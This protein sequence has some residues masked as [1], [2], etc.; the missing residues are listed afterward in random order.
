MNEF[1]IETRD[2]TRKFGKVIAVD[3]INIKVPK[4]S[5]YG[6]LGPNGAGKTTTIRMLLDLIRPDEGEVKLFDASLRDNRSEYLRRIGA[7]VETPSLYPHL[8]GGENMEITRL[9][10]SGTKEQVDKSL[11]FT[12][13][14]ESK[15]L[16]VKKYSHGM[17]QRL[18]LAL[19][20]IAD[21]ELLILDEPLSGL[22]PK[23]ILEFREMIN[24]LPE[25]GITVFLSSHILSEIEQT[26]G[27]IGIIHKGKMLF[28]GP[29]N[30]LQEYKSPVVK[31]RTGNPVMAAELLQEKGWRIR[32]QDGQDIE[33]S[34]KKEKDAAK[35]NSLLVENGIPVTSFSCEKPSLEELFLELT[36][37]KNENTGDV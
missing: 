20:L 8:T 1:V 4:G 21:P 7:L 24:C 12:G 2:L 13:I 5:V 28:Q 37:D 6:F 15:N 17:K 3:H 35:I 23:G 25:K 18:G 11:S 26:A 14:S 30:G 33:V 27:F 31:I 36:D 22:D 16:L 9:L 32:R 19:A 10:K 29:K 34:V